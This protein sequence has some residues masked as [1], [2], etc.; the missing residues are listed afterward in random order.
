MYPALGA[1][2]RGRRY[3]LFRMSRAHPPVVASAAIA[4]ALVFLAAGSAATKIYSSGVLRISIRDG[5]TIE[6]PINVSEAGPVWH[7]SVSVRID[8]P[9][10]SDLALALV[11]PD[12]STLALAS[13]QG[14]AGANFGSGARNCSG[15][16][17]EFDD[18]GD[19]R[20]SA[21]TPP[22]EGIIRPEERLAHLYGKQARGR[23]ALRITDDAPGKTG[24]LFCWRLDLSRNVLEIKRAGG[25]KVSAELSYRERSFSYLDVRLRILRTGRPVFNGPLPKA[26]CSGTCPYWRPALDFGRPVVVRDLDRDGDPEVVVDAFSG[27][28][29]CCFYSEIFRYVPASHSYSRSARYWGN[30]FYKLIDLDHDGSPELVSADDRFAYAFTSF[31]ASFDPVQVWRFHRGKLSDA[32]RS[33]PERVRKSAKELWTEYRLIRKSQFRDVRGVLAAYMADKY[34]LHEQEE[35]W[36]QLDGAYQRGELGRSSTQDGYPAGRTYLRRLLAFLRQTGYAR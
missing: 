22:F 10:A 15:T 16:L 23:W 34:L 33:F 14:G 24:T 3:A 8:H 26:G 2:R 20:V 19:V 11:A 18:G 13:H 29:H 17:T 32:T 21:S 35:G 27:G 9:R 12:G 5:E 28:A 30:A 1:T 4:L 36:K 6:Q 31:A 25:R 7:L